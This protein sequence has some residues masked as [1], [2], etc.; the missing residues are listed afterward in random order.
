MDT[1]FSPYRNSLCVRIC[2][3]GFIFL[4]MGSLLI[5]CQKKHTSTPTTNTALTPYT[6]TYPF[7]LP[8]VKIPEDNPLTVE[9]IALGKKLYGDPILSHNGNACAT[10][11]VK[12]TYFTSP[13]PNALPHINEAWNTHFLW[14]G[15]VEGTLEDAMKFE[16]GDF[17]QTDVSLL[18][19]DANYRSLFKKVYGV[20]TISRKDVAYALAQY[21]RSLTSFN[22]RFDKYVRKEMMISNSEL[23][24]FYIFNSEKG[25]CFHCHTLGLYTDNQYHNNGLDSSFGASNQGHF[26]ATGNPADLGKYKTPT[27]RN[28]P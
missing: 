4:M 17:F 25:E 11:H 7:N 22:S 12:Q 5:A 23:N 14:K 1:M 21:L 26:V 18:N 13:G 16:V 15:E 27:L 3:Q 10:C 24:G 9:G 19:Q 2:L 28:M 6:L 20:D 8:R